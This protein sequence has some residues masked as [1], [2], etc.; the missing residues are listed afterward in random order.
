M[1]P[2]I[3]STAG[4]GT[5]PTGAGGA[6]ESGTFYETAFTDYQGSGGASRHGVL[7][8]DVTAGTIRVAEGDVGGT[9]SIT[10]ATF[11]TS[12]NSLD[13]TQGCG[14]TGQGSLPYTYAAGVL[15]IYNPSKNVTAFTKQ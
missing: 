15:T 1:A 12:G 9:T 13:L 6:L 4:T 5:F 10:L 3:T 7:I 11:T 14:G 2:A 8:L